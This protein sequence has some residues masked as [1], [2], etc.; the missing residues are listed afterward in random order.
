MKLAK[1]T[2]ARVI[3][4]AC[5]CA[6]E[7]EWRQRLEYQALVD[8][9]YNPSTWQYLENLVRNYD[10]D[11]DIGASHKLIVD[12]TKISDVRFIAAASR[13]IS[14]YQNTH[15][16]ELDQW[17]ELMT[18]CL[19]SEFCQEHNGV[20][21]SHSHKLGLSNDQMTLESIANSVMTLFQVHSMSAI[22]VSS[23][24]INLVLSYPTRYKV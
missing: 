5:I 11:Y 3:I 13:S 16:V 21:Y 24:S 10:E 12:T 14:F 2:R 6:D 23:L 18:I 20:P 8:N 17:K 15:V 22:N 7:Y 4:V 1:S 19:K 9:S